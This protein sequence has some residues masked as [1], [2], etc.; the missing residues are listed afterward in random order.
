M[1]SDLTPLHWLH[2][3]DIMSQCG[4]EESEDVKQM[5]A[6]TVVDQTDYK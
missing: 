4:F 1:D 6:V 5:S 2:N 3:I